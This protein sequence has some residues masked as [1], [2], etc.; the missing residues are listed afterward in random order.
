MYIDIRCCCSN[1][2]WRIHEELDF[3]DPFFVPHVESSKHITGRGVD[4]IYKDLNLMKMSLF[5]FLTGLIHVCVLRVSEY[6]DTSSASPALLTLLSFS[7][8]LFPPGDS[9][10]KNSVAAAAFILHFLLYFTPQSPD[11]WKNIQ[12]AMPHSFFHST[13]FVRPDEVQTEKC[14][15]WSKSHHDQRR[16]N[17]KKKERKKSLFPLLLYASKL[18][19]FKSVSRLGCFTGRLMTGAN[20]WTKVF[21]FLFYFQLS[22]PKSSLREGCLER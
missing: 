12:Y 13:L 4:G 10:G 17:K 5:F 22:A 8:G 21:F 1:A 11:G 19:P 16:G 3:L 18:A 6:H 9:K 20:R 2:I 7:W 15:S 14:S